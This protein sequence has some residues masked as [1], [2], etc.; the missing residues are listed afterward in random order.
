MP[1]SLRRPLMYLLLLLPG[2]LTACSSVA[3]PTQGRATEMITLKVV[4]TPVLTYGPYFIAQEEGFFREQG[5]NIE[6]VQFQR[7]QDAIPALVQGQLD[8]LGGSL[9]FGLLNAITRGANIRIVAEKGTYS[10]SGCTGNGLV[11]R[12]DLVEKGELKEAAHLKGKRIAVNPASSTG[13]LLDT[14]LQTVGLSLADVQTVE[15]ADTVLPEALARGQLDLAFANEPFMTRLLQSGD[16]VLWQSSDAISPG[17]SYAFVS[18]GPNLL[19]KNPEVGQRFM[20]AYLKGVRQ[21][22]QGKTERNLEIMAKRTELERDLL[23][24]VCWPTF[25]T[26]GAMN[27]SRLTD[28]QTWANQRGYLDQ[29]VPQ[30]RLWDGRFI[31]AARRQLK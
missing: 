28:F 20:N 14:L 23:M 17:L 31:E 25:I 13:Y 18:Y 8:V 22:M 1:Y 15:V 24:R 5:L 6:L 30:D 12:R 10:T 19:E 7:S 4:Q 3:L 29:V 21:F 27:L 26:D 11:A 2:L 16:A 9:S